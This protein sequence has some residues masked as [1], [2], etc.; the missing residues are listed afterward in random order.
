MLHSVYGGMFLIPQT[1]LLQGIQQVQHLVLMTW[2][3]LLG[4]LSGLHCQ[5]QASIQQQ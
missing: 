3:G 4:C 1:L 2:N 5:A